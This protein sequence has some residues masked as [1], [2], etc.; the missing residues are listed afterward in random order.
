M[1]DIRKYIDRNPR[2]SSLMAILKALGLGLTVRQRQD[3][4]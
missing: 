4:A 1:A 2:L 3:A